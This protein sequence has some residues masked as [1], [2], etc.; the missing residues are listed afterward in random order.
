MRRAQDRARSN[1]RAKRA[2][3]DKNVPAK[4]ADFLSYKG[5]VKF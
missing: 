1:L 3:R 5:N 2:A 4:R